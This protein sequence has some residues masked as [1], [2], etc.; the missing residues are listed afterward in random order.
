MLTSRL[1]FQILNINHAL[2]FFLR[3]DIL[4]YFVPNL[5][6]VSPYHKMNFII[7]DILLNYNNGILA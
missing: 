4:S 1:S 7:Q 2:N 6:S 3:R 5:E